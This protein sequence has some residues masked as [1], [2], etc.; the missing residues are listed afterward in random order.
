[1]E[2][3]RPNREGMLLLAL[4][5]GATVRQAAEQACL[6]ERTVHRRLAGADFQQRVAAL[7]GQMVERALGKLAD[8]MA[9]AADTLRRLLQAESPS[10]RLGAA[11]SLRELG[12]KRRESGELEAR[13]RDLE[14][15]LA[16]S[17]E[18]PPL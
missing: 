15:L 8:G 9:E 10:V 14:S 2:N 5:G 1:A 17:E 13:L 4:A 18:E 11:R 6:S 16:E 3:G 12:V 7:R